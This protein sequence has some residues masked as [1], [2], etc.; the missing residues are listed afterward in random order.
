VVAGELWKAASAQ[1]L[2][3]GARARVLASRVT[4]KWRRKG[5]TDKGNVM[6]YWSSSF[7]CSSGS[8]RPAHHPGVRGRVIS[9]SAACGPSGRAQLDRAGVDRMVKVDLR[10]SRGMSAARRDHHDT[11]A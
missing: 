4:S 1:P 2:E 3:P 7:R 11:S 6:I 5:R 9:G 8:S 10:T